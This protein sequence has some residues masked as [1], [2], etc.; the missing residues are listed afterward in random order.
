M[1][2]MIPM[3]GRIMRWSFS[4]SSGCEM[5]ASKIPKVCRSSI[6]QTESGAPI[7]EL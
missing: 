3:V 4:I 7:C 6:C 1:L 2:V 5:P